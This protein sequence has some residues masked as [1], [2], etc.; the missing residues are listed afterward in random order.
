M[1]SHL[2]GGTKLGHYKILSQLGVGGMGE[3]Y[4][5]EDTK[6]NRKVAIKLLPAGSLE[7]ENANRRLLREAQSAANLDHPNICGILEVSEENGRNFICMQYV[8]GETLEARMKRSRLDNRHPLELSESLAIAIQ[9]ADA[10]AEAHGRGTIHR[11]IKPAN[12]MV[13]TRGAVKVMDFGLAKQIKQTDL[14]QSEA[15][16]EALLSTPGAI[17]G[18]LPYMSPEQVRGEALDGRSDIF[19]FGV[20]LYEMISGQQPF[21]SKSSAATAS[22]ILTLEPAP[23]ARFSNETPAELERIVSKALQKNPDDRYQTAR[24]LLIDLRS[25]RD[26]LEFQHR[27]ERSVPPPSHDGQS[28]VASSNEASPGRVDTVEQQATATVVDAQRT[29]GEATASS[30]TPGFGRTASGRTGLIVLGVLILAGAVGW[31]IWHRSNVRWAKTQVP[32]IEELANAQSFSEA[33][34]LAVAA[35]KYLPEDPTIARLMPTISQTISVKTDPAGA[36]VYLKRYAPGG[37]AD[38][39]RTLVGTTPIKDLRI[40]R[41]QYILYV[42][43]NGYAKTERSIS[44]AILHT[45]TLVV[46]P[47][48]INIDEKL[49]SADKV[50]DRM[51]FVPGGDYRLVA[52]AR[53]TEARVPLNDY[54]ID[55]YEVSNQE[56]K[57]FINA[58]GYLKKQYWQHSFVK[59]G[60]PLTWEDGQKEFKDRTG[61]PGPRDWSNQ[62]FPD[63]KADFPVANITWYEAAAYAAFRGKQLPTI[64]Q[65]EKAARNGHVST[66]ASFMPWGPFYPGETLDHRANFNIDGTMPVSSSGFGMSPFGSYNMAG[67]VSEWCFNEMSTGF[68]VTGGAWG[69]PSYTFAEYGSYPGFYSSD[70]VGF[71]CVLNSPGV[72]GDQGGMHIETKDEIPLYTPSSDADFN[73]WANYYRYDKTALDPQTVDVKETADWTRERITFNGADGQRAI[74]YLYLPKNYPRPLQVIHFAPAGDVAG[75]LRSLPESMEDRLAPLIK[76]GRAAFGVV[77]NGYSERLRPPGYVPPDPNTVEYRERSVNWITDVRRGLDYLET[78]NEIDPT[79]IAFMGPSAGARIGL[80]LAAVESRYRS[81][82]LMGAGVRKGDLE[83]IAEANPINFAPHIRGPKL[84]VSGRY[85]EDTPLKTQA[86]PLFKLLRDPKRSLVYDGGHVPDWTLLVKTI[87]GWLDETLGPVKHE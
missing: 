36:E 74:A 5:A 64:F 7:S 49:L 40:A 41:G 3:V 1:G 67:N 45:G 59:D 86:E 39:P 4:L 29:T 23:L 19:S 79:R 37:S 25:L 54:F 22:A 85:D 84:M 46:L 6:L 56:Y 75:G 66:M 10:L 18:T 52:W 32:H 13:T 65:W 16:T 17:I 27:L 35:Q 43:K 73:S 48:P 77:I 68:T 30:G 61:L 82:L 9:V 55:K 53:P 47:G 71:R 58:G 76:S 44:G 83:C 62:N 78:R 20:V 72:T 14:V 12:I 57:E 69:L 24:D 34:D 8:E 81:V 63:G 26:E 60:K 38:I 51:V 70:R 28:T 42:E 15:E 11:D 33:Y 50:P 31:F 21:A 2:P 87:N 80:I